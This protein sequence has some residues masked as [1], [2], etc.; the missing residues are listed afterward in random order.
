MAA[1]NMY[2]SLKLLVGTIISPL[3]SSSRFRIYFVTKN[4]DLVTK[5]L[6]RCPC[7]SC[8]VRIHSIDHQRASS[9]AVVD[10]VFQDLD[11][12]CRFN[13]DVEP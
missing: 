8:R 6:G 10:G 2:V 13:K 7:Y 12:S 9:S 11:A 3:G 1:G 4:S 5:D